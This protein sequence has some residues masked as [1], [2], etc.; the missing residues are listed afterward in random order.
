MQSIEAPATQA[1][2]YNRAKVP[3]L[4]FI[5]DV[6]S[7]IAPYYFYYYYYYYCLSLRITVLS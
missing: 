1:P 5:F 2:K 4:H 7:L 6:I 3:L